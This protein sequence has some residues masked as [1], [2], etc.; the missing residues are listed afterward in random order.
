MADRP[1]DEHPDPIYQLGKEELRDILD[2]AEAV[3]E[4]WGYSIDLTAIVVRGDLRN[5]EPFQ[6][7][8]VNFPTG[9]EAD[10]IRLLV[11]AA[12]KV[13]AEAELID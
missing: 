13:A 11:W 8:Q 2:A 5:G 12:Q 6:T 9:G 4:E 10:T 7:I 1:L 3:L